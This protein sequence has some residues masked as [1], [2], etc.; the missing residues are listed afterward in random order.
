[1]ENS[2]L[3][4]LKRFYSLLDTLEEKSKKRLLSASNGHQNWP[5]RGVY[6]FFEENQS[7][8]DS[9]N[10]LRVVR[11]GTHA[12]I[13]NSKST[14]WK[15]L[16]QHK[17]TFKSGGGNHRTSIFRLLLGTALIKKE[18]LNF[19]TWEN[20]N[21]AS[22]DIRTKELEL[23]KSVSKVIGKMPFLY[24]I[25]EDEAGPNSLRGYIEQNSISLLSN[26]CKSP[27][28]TASQEW[29]GNTCSREKVNKSGLWNQN[30][31]D[32][33]YDFNFLDIFEKLVKTT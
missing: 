22:K 17:G 31:V 26:Y 24:L 32:E 3:S 29:L 19:P 7:R 15:R 10:D 12:L 28:D 1:M 8:T 27:L 23:E 30:H 11:V 5:N 16:S 6:F 20:R 13:K 21:A 18:N 14:L 9:G 4:D 33:S 2:R 25:V